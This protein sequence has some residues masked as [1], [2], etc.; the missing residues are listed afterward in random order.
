MVEA[1]FFLLC[2]VLFQ[3][4]QKVGLIS[5]FVIVIIVLREEDLILD[6]KVKPFMHITSPLLGSTMN[7]DQ[8]FFH[9]PRESVQPLFKV[10]PQ[11]FVYRTVQGSWITK[12]KSIILELTFMT[13]VKK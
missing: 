11:I 10:L 1:L 9:F 4:L 3:H 7:W 8:G 2:V 6:S 13:P 12:T 5:A